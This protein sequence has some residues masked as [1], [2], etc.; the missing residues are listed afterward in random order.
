MAHGEIELIESLVLIFCEEM[1]V[2]YF[3]GLPKKHGVCMLRY[4][5]IQCILHCYIREKSGKEIRAQRNPIHLIS[6]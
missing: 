2:S 5:S 1:M 3:D 4:Q 6:G